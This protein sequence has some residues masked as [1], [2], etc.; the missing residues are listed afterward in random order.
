MGEWCSLGRRA[1]WR[2]WARVRSRLES[3]YWASSN[4]GR[5]PSYAWILQPSWTVW[6]EKGL[7]ISDTN[8][9]LQVT[10]KVSDGLEFRWLLSFGG[11]N[12][13]FPFTTCKKRIQFGAAGP[14]RR[15][16]S[17]ACDPKSWSFPK[18]FLFDR[19]KRNWHV[20]TPKPLAFTTCA[21]SFFA[22]RPGRTFRP[23]RFTACRSRGLSPTSKFQVPC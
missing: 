20:K 16:H 23:Y 10:K 5:V 1:V 21:T 14:E 2:R 7:R 6:N 3:T 22:T 12:E 19:Q 8:P 4:G 9:F 17:F 15:F 11:L 18:S 13:Q